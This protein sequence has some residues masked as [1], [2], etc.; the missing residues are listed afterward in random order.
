[1]NYIFFQKSNEI[2]RGT[3]A[4]LFERKRQFS[5][6]VAVRFL[7]GR[8]RVTGTQRSNEMN[9]P[10]MYKVAVVADRMIPWKESLLYLVCPKVE[11]KDSSSGSCYVRT[12]LDLINCDYGVKSSLAISTSIELLLSIPSILSPSVL[13]FRSLWC[14]L[15]L[16]W[17]NKCRDATSCVVSLYLEG[18]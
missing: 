18:L 11:Y 8:T 1:M 5:V 4:Y 13:P 9:T 7:F 14:D 6:K 15:R 17:C 16:E 3:D 2:I 10:R 12:Q